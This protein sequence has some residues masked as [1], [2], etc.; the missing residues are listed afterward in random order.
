M[1][2][3]LTSVLAFAFIVALGALLVAIVVIPL[4]IINKSVTKNQVKAQIDLLKA[5]D[6]LERQ[7]NLNWK[8]LSCG[9]SNHNCEFCEFCGTGK[10]DRQ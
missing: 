6:E 1:S 3:W 2:M 7:K 4:R 5:K 8:C 10:P 9:A